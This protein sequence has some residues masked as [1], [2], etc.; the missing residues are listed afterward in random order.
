[1]IVIREFWIGKRRF[2]KGEHYTGDDFQKY[3]N[4]GFLEDQT[5]AAADKKTVKKG[6][7]A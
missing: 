1:M 7:K 6:D 3:L 4:A 5:A 2:Y